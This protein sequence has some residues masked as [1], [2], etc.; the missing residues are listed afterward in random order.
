MN[1][2]HTSPFK[3]LLPPVE[4]IWSEPVTFLGQW[5]N[6][7]GLH[8]DDANKKA[9]QSRSANLDD[10]LKRQAFQKAHGTEKGPMERYFGFGKRDPDE[11]KKEKEEE[12]AEA[13][14]KREESR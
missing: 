13:A 7:M 8:F 11:D 1:F 3:H 2:A 5:K 12:A 9:F 6:V 4:N 14:R 10:V